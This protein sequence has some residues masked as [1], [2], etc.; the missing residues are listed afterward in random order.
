MDKS[1]TANYENI[2]Q[3]NLVLLEMAKQGEW[4]SFIELAADYIVTLQDAITGHSYD[5]CSDEKEQLKYYLQRMMD[6]ED[7]IMNAMKGR[8]DVLRRDMSALNL[9]KKC[10]QAY[11]SNF[12][13]TLQ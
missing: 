13:S 5:L 8:L 2:Y 7:I 12:T 6:N 9:G 10:N 1:I 11:S 3:Q 4:Q